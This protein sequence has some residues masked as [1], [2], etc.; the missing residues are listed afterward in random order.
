ME[1]VLSRGGDGN[2]D[3]SRSGPGDYIVRLRGLPYQCSKDEVSQFFS[4]IYQ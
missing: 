1:Y 2:S 3:S 4:G